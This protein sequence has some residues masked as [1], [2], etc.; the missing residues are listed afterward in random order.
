MFSDRGFVS[1]CQAASAG[2]CRGA[3]VLAARAPLAAL[4]LAPRSTRAERAAAPR[5]GRR[6]PGQVRLL[7]S[8]RWGRHL[9]KLV[10]Q[11]I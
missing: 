7:S 6:A 1:V 8:H 4:A 11:H 3:A 2:A 5:R 10:F 9:F